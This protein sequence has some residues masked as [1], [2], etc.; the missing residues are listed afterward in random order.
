MR[1]FAFCVLAAILVTTVRAAEEPE[2]VAGKTLEE[3]LKQSK[4]LD[5]AVREN[6][7]RAIVQFG[8]DARCDAADTR[9]SPSEDGDLGILIEYLETP[10]V[11]HEGQDGAGSAQIVGT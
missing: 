7:L 5:P 2:Q 6:S 8:K 3:W 10:H 4:S 9:E 1:S 11:R